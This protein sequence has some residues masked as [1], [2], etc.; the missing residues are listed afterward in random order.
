[1][2]RFEG[3][4]YLVN[5]ADNNYLAHPRG[6]NDHPSLG[7]ELVWFPER[8]PGVA[9]EIVPAEDF[10]MLSVRYDSTAQDRLAQSEVIIEKV[11]E[12]NGLNP[13]TSSVVLTYSQSVTNTF[14]YSFTESLSVKIT[15]SVKS[16]FFVAG[17][18]VSVEVQVGFSATQT[19]SKSV[20]EGVAVSSTETVTV[21]PKSAM[22]VQVITKRGKGKVPFVARVRSSTGKEFDLNGV[23]DVEL[24]FNQDVVHTQV[25]IGT[26]IGLGRD[27]L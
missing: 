9:V 14:T 23:A 19:V 6:R 3:R 21:P 10:T 11:V 17:A 22:K 15:N 26:R 18:K 24:F 4:T 5:G 2:Q 1:M 7:T 16:D 13:A 12:N 25:P 27:E 20:T 8:R